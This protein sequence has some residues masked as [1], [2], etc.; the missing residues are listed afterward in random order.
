M[1]PK[2]AKTH[3][4]RFVKVLSLKGSRIKFTIIRKSSWLIICICGSRQTKKKE[5]ENDD[6]SSRLCA[7]KNGHHHDEFANVIPDFKA[8]HTHPKPERNTVYFLYA[9]GLFF[10]PV[11]LKKKKK[12]N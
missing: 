11:F 5:K 9:D 7:S 2:F 8:I 12:E 1:D 4:F 6:S 3:K 10:F